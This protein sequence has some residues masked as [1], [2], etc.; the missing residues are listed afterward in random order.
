M[1]MF[2]I[3]GIVFFKSGIKEDNN[4]LS[5]ERYLDLEELVAREESR[6]SVEGEVGL[7][8]GLREEVKVLMTDA[9]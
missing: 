9:D 7:P 3:C 2:L 8:G 4:V 6:V 5:D 1:Y